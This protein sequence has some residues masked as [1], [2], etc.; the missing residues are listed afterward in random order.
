MTCV[1]V[2][3]CM[4]VCELAGVGQNGDIVVD[5]RSRRS[6]LFLVVVVRIMHS[7]GGEWNGRTESGHRGPIHTDWGTRAR[8]RPSRHAALRE[9][10]HVHATCIFLSH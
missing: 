1:I 5:G 2:L 9:T 3:G 8:T 6:L 4:C 10:I 7:E